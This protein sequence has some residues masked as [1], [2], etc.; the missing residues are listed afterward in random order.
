MGAVI[1][2]VVSIF[3]GLSW[4]ADSNMYRINYVTSAEEKMDLI[5]KDRE[6]IIVLDSYATEL[7]DKIIKLKRIVEAL[8]QPL[9]KARNREEEYLSNPIN[10]LSLMRQMH[11][12]WEPVEKLLKQ[13][14]GQEKIAFIEKMREDLP[15]EDD[16]IEANQA[17]FRIVHTYDLEPK[18]VSTGLIDG[19]QY[20]GKMSASDCLTMAALS[21]NSGSYQIASKWLSAA[22]D[23]LVEQPRKYHEVIGVTKADVTLLL[24]R[25]LIATGNVSIARDMLMRDSMLGE[26]GN[27]LALHFLRNTPKPSISLE[28]CES[29]ESFNHLCRS[30][31]RRQAGDSKPSR[32]HCRYNT[33]TRPFLR[34]VPLRMEELS[35]DPYVVLYHNVLSDPEIEKLKLMSEPFL[36]RAKV[37][38]VEKGSDEVAPSRSADGAW[39]PDPETEPED[40]ETLNRIGR[41]IGDITGLSTC[42][43]SQ[44]QLLKYGFGGHFVPHYDYFDSKTSYL[45]AVGDRIA[46]VLFYPFNLTA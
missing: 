24:A 18:D 43:G 7:K 27:A 31:S 9:E 6:L 25:S 12:D 15:V 11:D 8:K 28:C 32:L 3:L 22:K 38:R 37:Y 19:V 42:S 26:A 46:T 33:T 36:E 10:R 17:L 1:L 30:V 44:M 20:S 35:L 5:E 4:I 29:E 14:V 21:F 45:E 16:L 13:P 41:R 2:C 39:L 40:L 23:L 34:L